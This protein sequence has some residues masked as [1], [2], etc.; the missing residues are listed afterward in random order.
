RNGFAPNVAIPLRIMLTLPITVS[1]GEQSF[2][3]LKIIKNY[4]R[5]SMSQE[6]RVRLAMI[7]IENQT[8]QE[9]DFESLLK[10]F[11]NAKAKKVKFI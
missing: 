1:T 6:R 11:A 7:S 5:S 8:A 4:L 2:L 9:I 3:K 10:D